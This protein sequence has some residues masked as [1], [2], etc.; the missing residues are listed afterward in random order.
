MLLRKKG[1][2]LVELLVVIAIIGILIGMLL[3]AVQQVREAA[4]RTECLNKMRQLGLATLNFESAFM[5]FPPATQRR[6]TG[7]TDVRGVAPRVRPTAT[8]PND[9]RKFA[10]GTFI[11]PFVEQNALETQMKV[12]TDNWDDRWEEARVVNPDGSLGGWVAEAQLP[13]FICPSDA[14]PDGDGNLYYTSTRATNVTE[15]IV[16]GKSNYIAVAGAAGDTYTEN[17]SIGSDTGE[18]P[19][20][21]FWGIMG[22]NSR[23]D[24]ATI[25]DGSSNTIL[26]GE[27]A[28]RTEADSGNTDS[29]LNENYG[30]IWA[31]RIDSNSELVGGASGNETGGS[32]Y[33]IIGVA[34]S[35]ANGDSAAR[36]GVNGTDTPRGVAS[37]F[38]PGG[39][40][41]VFSDGSSHVLDNNLNITVLRNLCAMGDGDV[42][43][44]F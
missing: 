29:S 35:D 32:E 2:T 25:S 27:R 33:G 17:N 3:P 6:S 37:S 1:F 26:I 14:S 22:E 34:G 43:G 7:R 23:T 39:A 41:S 9:A 21:G 30:A 8:D 44:E 11:L 42:V 10:W 13:V 40:N 15:G 16:F 38:H 31:G 28:S 4:R 19:G 18:H 5:R 24:F 12:G 20:P 36:W